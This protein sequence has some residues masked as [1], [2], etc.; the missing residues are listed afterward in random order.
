MGWLARGLGSR[1]LV[2]S[3][4]LQTARRK[5]ERREAAYGGLE[6]PPIH[7]S[8]LWKF[9]ALPGDRM[10]FLDGFGLAMKC[11]LAF[12]WIWAMFRYARKFFA[13]PRLKA[14]AVILGM[15]LLLGFVNWS[16][17]GTPDLDHPDEVIPW[18][19]VKAATL[20]RLGR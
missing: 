19:D 3:R 9:S 15:S 11:F 20:A 8:G 6:P 17:Y 10:G 18:E 4:I 12:A 7:L 2:P 13:E 5:P 1:Y 16:Y 14:F